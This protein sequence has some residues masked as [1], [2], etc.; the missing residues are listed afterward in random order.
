MLKYG[1]RQAD[2][3]T[4]PQSEARD[5]DEF[6][7]EVPGAASARILDLLQGHHHQVNFQCARRD[8]CLTFRPTDPEHVY[9]LFA[10]LVL[11]GGFKDDEGKPRPAFRIGPD[12]SA[13]QA[14]SL[15]THQKQ[16][17]APRFAILYD[18]HAQNPDEYPDPGTLRL[19]FRWQPEKKEQKRIAFTASDAD[20]VDSWRFARMVL[21]V[22]TGQPRH[23]SLTYRPKSPDADFIAKTSA[24]V[25]SFGGHV[26]QGLN[27][28]GPA[29]LIAVA[30]ASI[31]QAEHPDLARAL[32]VVDSATA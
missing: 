9:K 13:W 7:L 1:R 3:L 20:L 5:A 2:N 21:E 27:L 19:E 32:P 22:L 17:D 18:K 4:C 16:S 26:A 30:L 23:K 12:G 10:D 15:Q 28:H 8:V 25:H 31:L 11:M 24:M 29:F 14:C 6:C